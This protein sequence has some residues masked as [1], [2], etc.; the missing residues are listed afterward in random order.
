MVLS[1]LLDECE[2]ALRLYRFM[3]KAYG[4]LVDNCPEALASHISAVNPYLYAE[5]QRTLEAELTT[6]EASSLCALVEG[7]KEDR[8][9]ELW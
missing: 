5:L 3:R 6:D 8:G 2:S 9:G 7:L 1:D 4:N